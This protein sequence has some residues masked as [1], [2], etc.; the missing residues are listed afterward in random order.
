M[1]LARG[2]RVD[3]AVSV[4]RLSSRYVH[5]ER[6]D[7]ALLHRIMRYIKGTIYV[8]LLL[9]GHPDD[10][11]VLVIGNW[12]DASHADEL[13]TAKSTSGYI[14]FFEGPRTW[15]GRGP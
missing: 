6:A 12:P 3:L 14:V 10:L 2:S 11:G 13:H 4:K 15:G 8:G 1:W 9:R 7:D 5:W